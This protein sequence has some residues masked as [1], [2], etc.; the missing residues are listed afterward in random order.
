MKTRE[1]EGEMRL[2]KT[3]L[4]VCIKSTTVSVTA[5]LDLFKPLNQQCGL[6]E[7]SHQV[8]ACLVCVWLH[9]Y[10][11]FVKRCVSSPQQ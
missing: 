6:E 10:A 3:C 9:V 8:T 11:Q 7:M 4:S 5:A 2:D 1:R